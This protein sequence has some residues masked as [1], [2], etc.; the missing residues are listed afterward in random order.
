MR[1]LVA[2]LELAL[3]R[4]VHAHRVDGAAAEHL[5]RLPLGAQAHQVAAELLQGRLQLVGQAPR[6]PRSAASAGGR[7]KSFAWISRSEARARPAHR[8][9]V[10]VGRVAEQGQEPAVVAV[11]VGPGWVGVTRSRAG[12]RPGRSGGRP[13]PVRC[14]AAPGR[15]RGRRRGRRRPRRRPA[16]ARASNAAAAPAATSPSRAR[17]DADA[18]VASRHEADAAR[19]DQ[20]GAGLR[21]GGS[22]PR[23]SP[24]SSA[25]SK[26]A[27]SSPGRTICS[28]RRPCLRPLN[29]VLS[30]PPGDFGPVDFRAFLRLASIWASAW[31]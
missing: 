18:G 4:L 23:P 27:G 17:L 3:L 2:V 12:R 14:S 6:S 11:G 1:H 19:L 15:P 29:F 22:S 20:G 28:A 31:P 21:S 25:R 8:V 26:A 13:R 9:G 16:R 7:S 10:G 24:L 5:R 30:L